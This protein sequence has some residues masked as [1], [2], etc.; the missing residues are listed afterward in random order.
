MRVRIE[1]GAPDS[2]SLGIA[3]GRIEE[4]RRIAVRK[5]LEELRKTGEAL[6]RQYCPKDYKI[7]KLN[8]LVPQIDGYA[9]DIMTR[10][11]PFKKGGNYNQA[12]SDL[13]EKIQDVIYA[14]PT[15]DLFYAARYT[16]NEGRAAVGKGYEPALDPVKA[17]AWEIVKGKTE[18]LQGENPYLPIVEFLK[19]NATRVSFRDT[20]SNDWKLRERLFV[21]FRVYDPKFIPRAWGIY[22][23]ACLSFPLGEGGDKQVNW[24]HRETADCLSGNESQLQMDFTIPSSPSA[25]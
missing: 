21:D 2:F 20:L 15:S 19:L 11:Q 10:I 23:K 9:Q 6:S 5:T 24:I 17:V 12:L 16:M 4:P 3:L 18:E 14:D 8:T 7:A 13:W 1:T 22:G 25:S